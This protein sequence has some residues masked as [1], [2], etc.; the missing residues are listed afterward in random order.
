MKVEVCT[1]PFTTPFTVWSSTSCT[2][3]VQVSSSVRVAMTGK[4]RHCGTCA[5][6]AAT[7]SAGPTRVG[8]MS[9]AS[10]ASQTPSRTETSVAPTTATVRGGI[11][12]QAASSPSKLWMRS[13]VARVA[14]ASPTATGSA[15][16]DAG[17]LGGELVL[18]QHAGVEQAL[19]LHELVD[20]VVLGGG[21]RG[22]G[23]RGPGRRP[24]AAEPAGPGGRRSA[25]AGRPSAGSGPA[26][27]PASCRRSWRPRSRLRRPWLPASAGDVVSSSWW[28]PGCAKGRD[29]RIRRR[30]PRPR[31]DRWRRG[32]G[33]APTCR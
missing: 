32:R 15:G 20:A 12:A 27:P 10:T 18:G 31:R 22:R 29:G 9:P 2:P 5:T 24:A 28:A 19:E 13:M 30:R 21:R 25:A 17:L 14:A 1:W 4:S 11:G 6:A 33:G 23:D 3:V 7:S 26:R 16:E 8:A